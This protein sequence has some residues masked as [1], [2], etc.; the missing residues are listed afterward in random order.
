MNNQEM[1]TSIN[2]GVPNYVMLEININTLMNECTSNKEQFEREL[3][4]LREL[5]RNNIIRICG[6]TKANEFFFD[7]FR[8]ITSYKTAESKNFCRA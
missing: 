1:Y 4:L 5:Y 7:S 3:S 6:Y 8:I 2:K